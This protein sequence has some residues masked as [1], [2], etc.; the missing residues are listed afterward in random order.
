MALLTA[1]QLREVERPEFTVDLGGGREVLV[2]AP[3]LQ[4]L[5]LKNIIS[6]PLL[7]EV[8]KLVGAWAGAGISDLTEDIIKSSDKLLHFVNV[9]VCAALVQPKAVMTVE[10]R[11]DEAVWVDDLTVDTKK[12][13]VTAVAR[14]VSAAHQEV[15]AAASS[16]PEGGPG[17]GAGPDVPALQAAAV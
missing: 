14:R 8:V 11:S 6:T 7:A 16:F 3:D 17:E 15:V 9:Y 2:R 4:L 5:V 12:T 10:E 1:T 13:I